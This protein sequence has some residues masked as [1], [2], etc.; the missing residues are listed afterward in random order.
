[1]ATA[2]PSE[3]GL[4]LCCKRGRRTPIIVRAG[5]HLKANLVLR[6]IFKSAQ[7]SIDVCDPCIGVRLSA[8]LSDKQLQVSVRILSADVKPSD[9]QRAA[10]FKKEH[11]GLEL[12]QQRSGMHDR[13]IIIDRSHGRSSREERH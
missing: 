1:M 3:I 9:R 10:D 2:W 7:S 4:L 5:E 11:G 13:F 12:R 6:Q 8:L